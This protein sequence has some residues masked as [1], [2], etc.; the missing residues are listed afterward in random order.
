MQRKMHIKLAFPSRGRGT[1]QWW[2]RLSATAVAGLTNCC[3]LIKAKA[4]KH[5]STNAVFFVILCA[6]G[7]IMF[8]TTKFGGYLSRLRKNADMT[9]SELA[10]RL[11]LTRQAISRYETSGTASPT[12]PCL[13][14]LPIFS[15]SR[16]T[17]SSI[18]VSRRAANSR[19]SAISQLAKTTCGWTIY[20]F[21]S[22]LRRCLSQVFWK[23]SR[24]DFLTRA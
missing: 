5:C 7:E 1:T 2:M 22:V 20:P 18:P 23:N 11:N 9:Q 4:T 10:D 14:S 19:C 16:L 21:T 17:N 13:C 6:G 8:N 12:F 24:R 15:V 3:F